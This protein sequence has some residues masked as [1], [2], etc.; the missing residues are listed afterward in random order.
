MNVFDPL[1]LIQMVKFETWKRLVNGE[2]RS[3]ILD[4]VYSND[5]TSIENVLPTD[6]PIGDHVLITIQLQDESKPEPNIS[7]KRNWTKYS[8]DQLLTELAG[9]DLNFVINDVQQCWNKIE[10]I[11]LR[12][13]DKVAPITQFTN[14]IF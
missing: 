11:M 5:I 12:V 13:T 4:H 9:E 3:S 14:D 8:K 10:E 6:M 7:Y 2:W 1:G